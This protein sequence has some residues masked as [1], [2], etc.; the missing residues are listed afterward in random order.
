M[1]DEVLKAILILPVNVLLTIPA[2]ILFFC[3]F[4]FVSFRL[5]ITVF[6]MLV[7]FALGLFLM[8][9][10]MRMFAAV[11]KGSLAPWNPINKLIIS[12]P[13]AYVRN[14]MLLGV[15]LFLLGEVILFQS[16]AL[17]I[18]WLIFICINAVYFPLSEEKGLLKRYGKEYEEYKNNVPRFIPRLTPYRKG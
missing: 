10:T 5:S 2:I 15:F 9:W 17:L 1:E 7:I 14:P 13:Y 3:G 18:Y 16:K 4:E 6:L 12:G 11:G 8:I